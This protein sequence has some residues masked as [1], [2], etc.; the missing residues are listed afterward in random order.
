MVREI[1]SCIKIIRK[2]EITLSEYET[3]L[4]SD[5]ENKLLITFRKAKLKKFQKLLFT[6]EKIIETIKLNFKDEAMKARYVYMMENDWHEFEKEFFMP[7]KKN[8][9]KLITSGRSLGIKWRKIK[10]INFD[11]IVDQGGVPDLKSVS[12]DFIFS[13]NGQKYT[14]YQIELVLTTDGWYISSLRD[15]GL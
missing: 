9:E 7:S 10:F 5:F 4:I 14:I 13:Y 11:Y 3:K 6:K 8:F 2:Q 1:A 12:G 15:E